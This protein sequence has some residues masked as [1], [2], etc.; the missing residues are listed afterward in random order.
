MPGP[1]EE[2]RLADRI[3]EHADGGRDMRLRRFRLI[4]LAEDVAM[5][6]AVAQ[7]YKRAYERLCDEEAE[8]E[9]DSLPL[10]D[11]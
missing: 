11:E 7:L 9:V 6:T 4:N 3:L 8:D 1:V 10:Q 5:L 2:Q